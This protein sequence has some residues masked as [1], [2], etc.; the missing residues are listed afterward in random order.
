MIGSS[1]LA[2]QPGAACRDAGK[3]GR[4]SVALAPKEMVALAPKEMV[5]L[6]PTEMVALAPK[7]MG[8]GIAASPHC[9]ERRIC[10]CS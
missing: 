6:A 2:P 10:R 3:S 8:A 7:E 9:A 1:L 5:A 4:A